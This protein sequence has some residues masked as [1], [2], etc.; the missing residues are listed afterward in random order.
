MLFTYSGHN[1]TLSAS[2]GTSKK[3]LLALA[4]QAS[5]NRQIAADHGDDAS[6]SF[7]EACRCRA[8]TAA[9]AK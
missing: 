4:K 1:Q 9:K 3:A 5:V 6:V 8:L 7:W 2:G